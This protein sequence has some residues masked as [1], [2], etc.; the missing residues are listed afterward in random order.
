MIVEHLSLPRYDAPPLTGSHLPYGH[1]IVAR[2][3]I[4]DN[5]EFFLFITSPTGSGKT[6]SWAVPALNTDSLGVVIALYPTNAL[7]EDQYKTLCH[8]RDEIRPDRTIEFLTSETL[9]IRAGSYD[10]WIS[11]GE[12]IRRIV[13]KMYQKGGGIIVTNPDIFVYVLKGY[14][15]DPYLKMIFQTMVQSVVF[16]E[17]HLYDLRQTDIILFLLHMVLCDDNS[18]M[19]KFIFL[20]ATPNDEILEKITDV[21]GGFL[22]VTEGFCSDSVIDEREILPEVE[23]EFKHATRFSA[24]EEFIREFNNFVSFKGDCRAAVILDSAHE[25]SLVSS[26][27]RDHTDWKI[28]ERSGFCKD[29][30]DEPFDVLVGNK[31]VE[32]GIDFKGS[33]AIQRLVF[34]GHDVSEFLQ[35]FGR[36]RNPDPTVSYRSI[37]YA[38]REVVDHMNRFDRL[39]RDKLVFELESVMHDPRVSQSFRWRYG[40]LEAY[41]FIHRTA[42]GTGIRDISGKGMKTRTGGLSQDYLLPF[43]QTGLGLIESHY[44]KDSPMSG[45][46]L[47]SSIG[48]LHAHQTDS[49][50]CSIMEELTRFRGSQIDLAYYDI[51]RKNFGTYNIFFLLR[52]ADIE[53]ISEESFMSRLSEDQRNEIKGVAKR[54]YGFCLIVKMR[55]TPRKVSLTGREPV[56]ATEDLGVCVPRR[57]R[58]IFPVLQSDDGSTP[59]ITGVQERMRK[60]GLFC[61]YIPISGWKAKSFYDL[62][63]Y[64]ALMKFRDCS[65]ALGIDGLYVD[66]A[67]KDGL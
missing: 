1:Q 18:S 34:S 23:I 51:E 2:R 14:Y 59:D 60:E 13:Q 33:Y 55:N 21:I 28:C 58:G 11:K 44:L 61:R 32:V 56:Q 30:L 45:Q 20:S 63:D 39:S 24:G 3:T 16:D 42:F 62:S 57:E 67:I 48:M 49:H 10:Y 46:D 5:D 52:W 15:Q 47:F 27:L 35:R 7:A 19:K 43:L 53:M 37:C 26:F 22:V 8:L 54:V 50:I 36:L 29:P 17:F 66:C 64:T 65:L 41:E 4:S 6:E 31:T 9:G 12:I 25:V 38:P 40:Y